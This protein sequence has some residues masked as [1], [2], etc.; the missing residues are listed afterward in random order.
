MRIISSVLVIA[1]VGFSVTARAVEKEFK[2]VG[3]EFTNSPIAT[4]GTAY[5]ADAQCGKLYE[6]ASPVSMAFELAKILGPTILMSKVPELSKMTPE[7]KA[8]IFTSLRTLAKQKVWLPVSLE[9]EI[10]A[11]MNQSLLN[12]KAALDPSQMNKKDRK[13][14]ARIK[15]IFDSVLQSL[16]SDNPYE[17]R[18]AVIKSDLF[19]AFA[20]P[21]GYIYITQR[22]MRNTSL[23]D[24]QLAFILAHEIA[25][26]TKRHVLREWQ[27]KAV[28]SLEIAKSLDG[29]LAISSDPVKAVG[30]IIG[31]MGMTKALFQKFDIDNEIEGDAC[32]TQLL[33]K[34]AR[35][36]AEEQKIGKDIIAFIEDKKKQDAPAK[37]KA[38]W[39][40]SH[41]SFADREKV[42]SANVLIIQSHGKDRF[43]HANVGTVTSKELIS[44][45]DKKE[46]E[47]QGGFMSGL[48]NLF[49]SSSEEDASADKTSD[50]H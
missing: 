39:Y 12:D 8:K 38:Q 31:T 27:I 35:N 20:Q 24:D 36:E 5:N 29:I 41:P 44:D 33:L 4:L 13:S 22:L 23:K 17:F 47:D 10:G 49:S 7:D 45:K 26:V 32:G 43:V 40:V 46:G 28:D 50:K 34:T 15:G 18:L 48:T 25:H 19:N 1:L 11:V 30:A 42:A 3:Q 14:Y 6:S 16:P 37:A 2:A 21:G 9:Q